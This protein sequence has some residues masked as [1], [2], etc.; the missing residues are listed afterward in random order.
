MSSGLTD[1]D[2]NVLLQRIQDK[3]CTPF[4]GAGACAG[5]AAARE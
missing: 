5:D 1:A 4:I 3:E 2:W